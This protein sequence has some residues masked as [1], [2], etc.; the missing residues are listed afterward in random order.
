LEHEDGS[1]SSPRILQDIPKVFNSMEKI[2]QEKGALIAGIGDR[3]GRRALQQHSSGIN[4]HGGKRVRE[5][6]KDK[7]HWIHPDAH[8]AYALKLQNSQAV[9]AGRNK[10]KENLDSDALFV[11]DKDEDCL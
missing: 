9:H 10:E 3:K 4:V 5:K 6:E 8:S 2:G 1:P 11:D 7:V